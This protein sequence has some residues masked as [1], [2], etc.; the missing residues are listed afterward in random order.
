MASL[1][2][3]AR[4]ISRAEPCHPCAAPCRRSSSAV[5]PPAREPLEDGMA[6]GHQYGARALQGRALYELLATA[7]PSHPASC[8]SPA[9]PAQAGPTGGSP[10]ACS[11]PQDRRNPPCPSLPQIAHQLPNSRA[12]LPDGPLPQDPAVPDGG[13]RPR[14]SFAACPVADT[15][16]TW[17]GAPPDGQYFIELCV[18]K[19]DIAV[20][21]SRASWPAGGPAGG[22]GGLVNWTFSVKASFAG[23]LF[24]LHRRSA[25]SCGCPYRAG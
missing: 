14:A 24:G 20:G 18:H 3:S 16:I 25:G 8:A 23:Q 6:L 10:N 22:Y 13:K 2:Q 17:F 9:W 11:S 4:R 15:Q 12:Q 7:T 5:A 21:A 19:A 1:P